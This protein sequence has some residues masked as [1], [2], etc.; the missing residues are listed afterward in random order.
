VTP[1]GEVLVKAL[2]AIAL[3]VGCIWG[4]NHY[5]DSLVAEGDA[6]GYKRAMDEA[7][8]R[9]LLAVRRVR[10]E[11]RATARAIEEELKHARIENIAL[12]GSYDDAVAAGKRL[13]GQLAQATA[14]AL[15]RARSPASAAGGSAPADPAADLLAD[16]QRR[17]EEAENGTI[18]FADESHHNGTVCE[19]FDE[20]VR[21][22]P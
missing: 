9:E 13:S 16:V 7:A 22:K 6:A 11:E 2:I 14:E 4:W 8:Q 15:R 10:E 18:R 20:A 19:R 3:V 17:L 5:T 1:A 21:V 12:R